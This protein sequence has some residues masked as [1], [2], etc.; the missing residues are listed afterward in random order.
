MTKLPP[1]HQP[2]KHELLEIMRTFTRY[3]TKRFGKFL[4][5]WYFNKSPKIIKL[6]F[7]LKKFFPYYRHRRLTKF[8]IYKKL[9]YGKPYNDST[10]RNLIY[11]LQEFAERFMKQVEFDKDKIGNSVYWRRPLFRRRLNT[12][13]GINIENTEELAARTK[14]VESELYSNK[15]RL[16]ADNF[17]FKTIEGNMDSSSFLKSDSAV[18]TRS[19]VSM[20]NFLVMESAKQSRMMLCYAQKFKTPQRKQTTADFSKIVDIEKISQFIRKYSPRDI[21]I[22]QLYSSLL[23]AYN[24]FESDAY[25]KQ[26]KNLLAKNAGKLT[27]KES[28]Q[29]YNALADYNYTKIELKKSP[30]KYAKELFDVFQIIL[31]NGYYDTFQDNTIPYDLL[32]KVLL[33]A[34]MLKRYQWAN[35]FVNRQ[36]NRLIG[37]IKANVVAFTSALINFE[38]GKYAE[39]LLILKKLDWDTFDDVLDAYELKTKLL[40]ETKDMEDALDTIDEYYNYIYKNKTIVDNIRMSHLNFIDFVWSMAN[41]RRRRKGITRDEIR[42]SF[43]KTANVKS[44][45]WIAAKIKALS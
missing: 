29:L 32:K 40:Y 45:D 4:R 33:N 3:E 2:L 31:R 37:D 36:K 27:V 42:R 34:L 26:F 12:I 20:L 23:K 35:E 44:R 43:S 38:R 11:D 18:I 9:A 28:E 24:N 15:Y 25:Y 17:L 39:A 13:N 6:F 41:Y 7:I 30:N 22:P 1:E 8:H 10:V 16:E 5:S 19:Y 14:K 21:W